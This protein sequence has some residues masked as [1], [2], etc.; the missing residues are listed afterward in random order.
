MEAAMIRTID[1]IEVV[2]KLAEDGNLTKSVLA[3]SL[4]PEARYAFLD[5]CA[6]IERRLT[7]QCSATGETCLESGCAL[8]G[9]AC[10]NAVLNADIEYHKACAAEWVNFFSDPVNRSDDW[11]I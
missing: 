10:L 4:T 1:R 9:E 6:A 3:D 8:E 7:T 2:V 5:K 11:S